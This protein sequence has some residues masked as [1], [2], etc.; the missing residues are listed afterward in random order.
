MRGNELLYKAFTYN[1]ILIAFSAFLSLFIFADRGQQVAFGVALGGATMSWGMS[2]LIK[3]SKT[4]SEANQ[5]YNKKM[6]FNYVIRY[7][8]YGIVLFVSMYYRENIE[9]WGTV[10]GLLSFK[11]VL[12]LTS[13]FE[14]RN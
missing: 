12:Y 4:L 8:V 10:Y 6:I 13:V 2:M 5:K 1:L 14:K 3:Q 9:F 7:L 11:I